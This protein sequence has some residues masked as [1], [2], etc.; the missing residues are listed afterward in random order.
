MVR[1]RITIPRFHRES[2]VSLLPL[3]NCRPPQRFFPEHHPQQSQEYRYQ[4]SCRNRGDRKEK[5]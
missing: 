5:E 3:A 1:I 2:F 4:N